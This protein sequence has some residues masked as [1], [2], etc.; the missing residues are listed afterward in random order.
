MSELCKIWQTLASREAKEASSVAAPFIFFW[1]ALHEE[2]KLQQAC[3][4]LAKQASLK[5]LS[6]SEGLI[7]PALAALPEGLP[8]I[9]VLSGLSDGEPWE[10]QE[11]KA[12]LLTWLKAEAPKPKLLVLVE[13]ANPGPFSE[14][15]KKLWPKNAWEVFKAKSSAKTIKQEAK[16]SNPDKDHYQSLALPAKTLLQILS[17]HPAWLSEAQLQNLSGLKLKGFKKHLEPLQKLSWVKRGEQFLDRLALDNSA[18]QNF[19]LEN[20][21]DAERQKIH[22]Q[23]FE[24]FLTEERWPFRPTW[25][26]FHSDGA[27]A[28]LAAYP[29][30]LAAGDGYRGYGDLEKAMAYYQKAMQTALLLK[31]DSARAAKSLSPEELLLSQQHVATLSLE[32]AEYEAALPWFQDLAA[33]QQALEL[34]ALGAYLGCFRAHL[35]LG[36]VQVAQQLWQQLKNAFEQK[37]AQSMEDKQTLQWRALFSLLEGQLQL[38]SGERSQALAGLQQAAHGFAKAGDLSGKIEVLLNL[39]APL[40]ELGLWQEAKK[41]LDPVA[42]WPELQA[43]PSLAQS[44]Y[45]RQRAVQAFEELPS[46]DFILWEFSGEATG[47]K[48]NLPTLGR[49]EDWLKFYFH[50]SLAAQSA[51]DRELFQFC[52]K[53]AQQI[54]QQLMGKFSPKAQQSFQTRPDIARIL[55]LSA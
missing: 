33:Q 24:L 16:L 43:V 14:G 23:C 22:T 31:E 35:G 5:H 19:I 13:V 27:G 26:A 32:R 49:P 30:Q 39:T 40:I 17:V 51:Q 4:D 47:H 9:L 41:L 36:Q 45:L 46:L 55:R 53:R 34:P 21:A 42:T 20:L 50:L 44:F 1:E 37:D 8:Q 25:L 6:F 52:L 48:N 28:G 2:A 12:R 11:L 38:L 18:V 15:L 3:E 10:L 54:T 29:W 7:F